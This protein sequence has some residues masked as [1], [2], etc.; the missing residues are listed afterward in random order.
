MNH[1]TT[2]SI[3]VSYTGKMETELED[4]VE[5]DKQRQLSAPNNIK[6]A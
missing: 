1:P 2:L 3:A 4:E 6:F 5:N